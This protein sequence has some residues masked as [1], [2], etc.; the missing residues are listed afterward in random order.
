MNYNID[1][2]KNGENIMLTSIV[3]EVGDGSGD[4]MVELPQEIIDRFDLKEGDELQ[5]E[6]Q[7]DMIILTPKKR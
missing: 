1:Y 7:K 2:Q 5:L 4:C 6:M 3:Q